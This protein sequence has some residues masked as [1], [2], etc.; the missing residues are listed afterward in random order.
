VRWVLLLVVLAALAVGVPTLTARADTSAGVVITVSGNISSVLGLPSNFTVTY[1]SDCEIQLSWVKGIG[2]TNTMIRAQ[3]G[4]SPVDRTDG[5]IVYYGNGTSVTDTWC[6]YDTVAPVYYG[7]WSQGNGTWGGTSS[8]NNV[9]G[10]RE[11]TLLGL[12]VFCGILSWV[13]LKSNFFLLK[14]LAGMAWFALFLY[15]KSYPPG[16]LPEGS[17][18]HV[19]IML[20]IIGLGLAIPLY[21][22]GREISKQQSYGEG[23]SE[24]SGGFRFS[25]PEWTQSSTAKFQKRKQ[26]R[27]GDLEEYRERFHRA[28]N[29][30]ESNRRY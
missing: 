29:P 24:T 14:L 21:G 10:G 5:R 20:V 4:S 30:N 2:A 11:V 16:A 8:S 23:G 7:A 18:A 15:I 19:A 27:M 25:R 13:S 6:T 1:I 12:V 22:L 17:S 9:I 28:L 3:E 26:K